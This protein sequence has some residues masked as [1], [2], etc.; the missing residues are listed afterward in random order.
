MMPMMMPY[1]Q[2]MMTAPMQQPMMPAQMQPPMM[3][4]GKGKGVANP[5]VMVPPPP[6][7]PATSAMPASTGAQASWNSAMPMMPFPVAPAAP[8]V[9]AQQEDA[10]KEGKAQKNLNRLLKELKKEEDTL[11]PNLQSMAHEMKKQDEKS[12][13][14]GLHSAVRALGDAKDELL[15]A[16]NA[17]VQ[18]LSQWKHFL[19]QSVVKWKEFTMNFQASDSAHQAS[20]HAA[21]LA[22]RRAQRSFDLAS[23]REHI[24]KEEPWPVSDEEDEAAEDM[25]VDSKEESAQKIHDGMSSIVASLEELSSSADLLEQRVKRPRTSMGNEET[26]AAEGS[27]FR[28]AGDT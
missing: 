25:T 15:E 6:P 9:P 22:V 2:H 21:R 4:K 3:D 24:G 11:S 12:N 14:R 8:T 1:P 17:R 7:M 27:S 28:K 13:M 20:V 19:Q 10:A 26:A 23:K 18:L 5:V 16:E